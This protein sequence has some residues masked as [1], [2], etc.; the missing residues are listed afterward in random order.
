M[1]DEE[2]PMV[3]GSNG[4]TVV[5]GTC[6]RKSLEADN[7]EMEP[8]DGGTIAWL[9]MIGSFLCNGILFG[10]INTYSVLYEEIYENLSARNV[11]DASSKAGNTKTLRV[12]FY[13]S[14]KS[15]LTV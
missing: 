14:D 1:C 10:V 2:K 6:D 8:P 7:T 11:T 4:V 5:N 15:M 12:F 9:V 3:N 13:P